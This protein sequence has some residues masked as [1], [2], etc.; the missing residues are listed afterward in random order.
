MRTA[1]AKFW[2]SQVCNLFCLSAQ[3]YKYENILVL[4]QKVVHLLGEG[5]REEGVEHG[6][7]GRGWE[8]IRKNLVNFQYKNFSNQLVKYGIFSQQNTSGDA[9]TLAPLS[10]KK[11]ENIERKSWKNQLQMSSLIVPAF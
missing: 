11:K 10:D 5:C 8:N 6:G 3:N 4:Y 2:D 7:G 1:G 9:S